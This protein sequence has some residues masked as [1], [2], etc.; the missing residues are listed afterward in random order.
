M[1]KNDSNI[2]GPCIMKTN[3]LKFWMY[4]ANGNQNVMLTFGNEQI[5]KRSETGLM[6]KKYIDIY[7]QCHM[8]TNILKFRMY[9]ANGN[10]DLNDNIYCQ[11]LVNLKGLRS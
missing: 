2:N 9:E 3:I 10:Q 1:N 4:E 5:N 8:K 7:G 6:S 11:L